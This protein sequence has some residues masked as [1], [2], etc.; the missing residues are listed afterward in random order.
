MATAAA[1]II[2]ELA[3]L[4][5]LV[6]SAAVL[7]WVIRLGVRLRRPGTA[8]AWGLVDV[9]WVRPGLAYAGISLL[10]V[11][12]LIVLAPDGV[13]PPFGRLALLVVV[14]VPW[15]LAQQILLCAVLACALGELIPGPWVSWVAGAL[16][17]AS[18][19]PDLPL[20]GL[21]LVVGV[22]WVTIYRSW[23]N[24]WLSTASH[25]ILGA[26]AYTMA[27]GRDPLALLLGG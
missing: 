7:F 18:H 6:V 17:A 25:S 19:L 2:G 15:A 26:V 3:G 24:L 21:T 9:E 23:A 10:G 12:V 4:K 1:N 27:L 8:R 16:F 13:A 11:V 20:A 14:Y 22:V 5:T